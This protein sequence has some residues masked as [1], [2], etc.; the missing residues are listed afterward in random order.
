MSREITQQGE[1]GSFVCLV[2]DQVP[3]LF[4]DGISEFQ[5]GMP[6]SRLI[7]H[8]VQTPGNGEEAERRIAKLSLVMPTNALMELVANIATNTSDDV[9][10]STTTASDAFASQARA[11]MKRLNELTNSIEKRK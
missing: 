3:E 5:F 4:A 1:N 8:A 11:Q 10:A 9:L 6:V 2:P 7:F